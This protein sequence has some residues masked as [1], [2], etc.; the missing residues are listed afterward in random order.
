M[1]EGI[2]PP[3]GDSSA[4][5]LPTSS[6]GRLVGGFYGGCS[7][8]FPL[9]PDCRHVRRRS[10]G[11]PCTGSSPSFLFKWVHKL[12]GRRGGGARRRSRCGVGC[13]FQVRPR[14]LG[15]ASCGGGGPYPMLCCCS[16]FPLGPYT[17]VTRS[18]LFW[19]LLFRVSPWVSWV[20]I[21]WSSSPP[22]SFQSVLI[23]YNH[24]WVENPL[25]GL[26]T[27]RPPT[28]YSVIGAATRCMLLCY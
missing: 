18:S 26:N 7:V 15:E 2:A 4:L 28:S 9:L 12:L 8:I 17:L 3:V 27:R 22:L 5:C 23:V 21:K 14:Q 20:H 1:R 24:R 13:G 10:Q 6:M 19:T 25:L 16:D 11:L